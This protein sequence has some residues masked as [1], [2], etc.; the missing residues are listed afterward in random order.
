[1]KSGTTS[2]SS[3]SSSSSTP[4]SWKF[5]ALALVFQVCLLGSITFYAE[6][7][8][9]ART[10]AIQNA[11]TLDRV[12]YMSALLNVVPEDSITT[13]LPHLS[14]IVEHVS[15]TCEA[16]AEYRLA[17]TS[18][19][20]DVEWFSA[21][22]FG[23]LCPTKINAL[24]GFEFVCPKDMS[25]MSRALQG[26]HGTA[27][28]DGDGGSVTNYLNETDVFQ[29]FTY[30]KK[31]KVGV[32]YD[33]KRP[34]S[35]QPEYEILAVG[36][37][38]TIVT[39][40]LYIL[41][42]RSY[43]HATSMAAYYGGNAATQL[44]PFIGAI[45]LAATLASIQEKSA[46]RLLK[47]QLRITSHDV[48]L[49]LSNVRAARS[50][51]TLVTVQTDI[52]V[53]LQQ[54]EVTSY[55]MNPVIYTRNDDAEVTFLI[56]SASWVNA[57]IPD[58]F[59]ES[60]VIPVQYEAGFKAG[61]G[62]SDDLV[63]SVWNDD[64]GVGI[65]F[66]HDNEVDGVSD[67]TDT[68]WM[69]AM[70]TA[71]G[72]F[73][74]LLLASMLR[75]RP[76][77]MLPAG[78]RDDRDLGTAFCPMFAVLVLFPILVLNMLGGTCV[79]ESHM[80]FENVTALYG[81][82]DAM[83]A[84]S[85]AGMDFELV[86]AAGMESVM[87]TGD[88]TVFT[89][90][91]QQ[92]SAA[93]SHS[94]SIAFLE[95]TFE[96]TKAYWIARLQQRARVRYFDSSV[97]D[98]FK[99]SPLTLTEINAGLDGLVTTIPSLAMLTNEQKATSLQKVSEL[100]T[101]TY[102][103]EEQRLLYVITGNYTYYSIKYV[104]HS[105]ATTPI[106][107][108]LDSTGPIQFYFNRYK[109]AVSAYDAAFD[110]LRTIHEAFASQGLSLS[111]IAADVRTY[112]NSDAVRHAIMNNISRIEMMQSVEAQRLHILPFE[113]YEH[114]VTYMSAV[115]YVAIVSTGVFVAVLFSQS[116]NA[117]S[118]S[119]N[120]SKLKYTVRF[121]VIWAFIV[122]ATIVMLCL[123]QHYAQES[124]QHYR[125]SHEM[126]R[127]D[128][129]YAVRVRHVTRTM[130]IA[131]RSLFE[132]TLTSND[133]AMAT[134]LSSFRDSLSTL[135]TLLSYAPK[136]RTARIL[137][138]HD[139]F[140]LYR[141]NLQTVIG[142]LSRITQSSQSTTY[143]TLGKDVFARAEEDTLTA[144]ALS[145]LETCIARVGQ[146]SLLQQLMILEE[147]TKK[148]S[149]AHLFRLIT[150]NTTD[151][152]ALDSNVTTAQRRLDQLLAGT[153]VTADERACVT[154]A[155]TASKEWSQAIRQESQTALTLTEQV[156]VEDVAQQ[157]A[158]V[159]TQFRHI[160][161]DLHELAATA[162][163]CQG[164]RD[165]CVEFEHRAVAESVLWMPV[166]ATWCLGV[167]SCLLWHVLK[168]VSD[169]WNY[170]FTMY[171]VGL[172]EHHHHVPASGEGVP[173]RQAAEDDA[174]ENEEDDDD[175]SDEDPSVPTKGTTTAKKSKRKPKKVI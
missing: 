78:Q 163:V 135:D 18:T 116:I 71:A 34:G 151:E 87:S 96:P 129:V 155:V 119:V 91:N 4:M 12:L 128:E 53:F 93:L 29:S 100:R 8:A 112:L 30:N 56:G 85:N 138:L 132:Y 60:S 62:S 106:V 49:T 46:M 95:P 92:L 15:K 115:A 44:L 35:F 45:V 107:T 2:S 123:L 102:N 74:F 32:L 28:G 22:R 52:G 173:L 122:F 17:R 76:V 111:D 7:Q 42:T 47:H 148:L 171:G 133:V 114:V 10:N 165:R 170:H 50:A 166:I 14:D 94:P 130:S 5:V 164:V 144:T 51:D 143:T 174:E 131:L 40:L 117:A 153:V 67:D 147:A 108:Y 41:F 142:M 175:V 33:T 21:F 25:Y 124:I 65:L 70:V 54:E 140:T 103:F 120:P 3:P 162:S 75:S 11:A 84:A 156:T 160:I 136:A 38:I 36:I 1:M 20:G 104:E 161:N 146:P 68:L 82:V 113:D 13:E 43:S 81:A 126:L 139:E 9:T 167:V 127:R 57:T 172:H 69:F 72:L 31:H 154:T 66:V 83:A 16:D 157:L 134:A 48:S 89:V 137:R 73:V 152:D 109:R 79:M 105:A 26:E 58:Y 23:A 88:S 110:K 149:R 98:A 59:L 77:L 118:S 158:S 150:D 55:L 125:Q 97:R 99:A 63:T 39:A 80:A 19:N 141:T 64:L 90:V 24:G 6:R 37:V 27:T 169:E 101:L 145:T 121:C 168:E 86:E 159:R 61:R